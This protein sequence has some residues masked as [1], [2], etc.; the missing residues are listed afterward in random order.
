MS[1]W[2][3]LCGILST[4]FAGTCNAEKID[5]FLLFGDSYFDTGAGDALA[6]SLGVF[7][8]LLLPRHTLTGGVPTDPSGLT[9]S[10]K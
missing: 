10:V 4:L 1:K 3:T 2:I 6:A 8:F 5:S 7:L 9:M